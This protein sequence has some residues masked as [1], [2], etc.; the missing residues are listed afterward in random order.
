MSRHETL[1]EGA[2]GSGAV[3][4]LGAARDAV[5][6][7]RSVAGD[8]RVVPCADLSSASCRDAGIALQ[9]VE[10]ILGAS[11]SDDFTAFPELR[12]VHSSAAG[13]DA[14]LEYGRLPPHVELTSAAGNG[15]IPMAEHALMLMLML[16]R[17][18]PR[19]F[20]AQQAREWDRHTHGELA[21]LTLGIVGYGNSGRDLARK[22]HTCH[23]KVKALRRRGTAPS[24][25]HVELLYG[26]SGLEELMATSDHVVVTAPLTAQTRGLI[27][28]AEL[29]TMRPGAVLIV[30]SR[31]GIV[32]EEALIEALRDGRLAGAGLDAHVTEPLPAESPLWELP[33]VIVTPHN[34]A[35]TRETAERG[36]QILLDNL[37][38]WVAGDPLLNVVDRDAGY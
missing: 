28:A 31:G 9:S 36:R 1:R 33:G 25:G 27:G 13:V 34:G 6:E 26:E 2:H 32:E 5:D 12:W 10:A 35:T 24:D 38:R 29:S 17:D 37:T 18:A 22:A 11:P 19:W 21:G 23:M 8:A 14:W 30:T 20:R 15:A 3:V 7:L 16:N 4:L